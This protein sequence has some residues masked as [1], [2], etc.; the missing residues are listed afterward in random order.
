MLRI[1]NAFLFGLSLLLLGTILSPESALSKTVILVR[2]AENMKGDDPG[3]TANGEARA[4]A[5]ARALREAAI[6]HVI[7]TQ[8]RR[9]RLTAAPV[10]VAG[11]IENTI[12]AVDHDV[13]KHLQGTARAIKDLPDD[14]NILV[15]GHSNTIPHIVTAL[16]GPKMTDLEH[17]EYST[18][19]IVS[20][21]HEGDISFVKA[22]FGAMNAMVENDSKD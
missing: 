18:M 2:H 13:T 3:L 11:S 6:S 15:V 9:T 10:A 12:I 19:F 20:I 7:T 22:R 17:E 1:K 5:L 16:G 21:N 14:A 4:Q 8:L